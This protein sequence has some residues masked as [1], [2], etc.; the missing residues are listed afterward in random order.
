MRLQFLTFLI[1]WLASCDAQ[2]CSSSR[3]FAVNNCTACPTIDHTRGDIQMAV[4]EEREA[5]PGVGVAY[6]CR[7]LDFPESS[8]A[9]ILV[10]YPHVE[11]NATRC[12]S[13]WGTAPTMYTA[14]VVVCAGFQLFTTM[15]FVYI[16]VFTGMCSCRQHRCTKINTSA[17]F[18]AIVQPSCP[19]G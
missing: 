15:H 18:L 3:E 19:H 12:A 9:S 17:L 8:G 10:Y 4:C 11:G 5:G 14:F 13:S 2:L 1:L 6:A 7:C 16:V